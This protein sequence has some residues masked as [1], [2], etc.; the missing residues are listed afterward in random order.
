[1][2]D[3]KNYARFVNEKTVEGFSCLHLCA[4]WNAPECLQLL[5]KFGGVNLQ[6]KDKTQTTAYL[7]AINYKRA[8]MKNILK[9]YEDVGIKFLN[10]EH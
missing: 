5:L 7:T 10:V 2:E 8:D 4:I 6:S 3:P 9:E 1:M